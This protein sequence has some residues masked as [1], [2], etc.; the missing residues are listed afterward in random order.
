MPEPSPLLSVIMP[1]F[2]E[3]EYLAFALE[4]VLV[5]EVDFPYEIIVVDDYSTDGTAA[6]VERYRQAFPDIVR[7]AIN[8][9]N[10]GNAYSFWHGLTLSRGEFFHVLDGDDFF[11]RRDKLQRQVDFLQANPDFA[12][13]ATNSL[14]MLPDTRFYSEVP[15]D[16]GDKDYTYK[17]VLGFGF[18]FHTS[19]Y[20]YRNIYRDAVPD[21]LK[22]EW[23]RGDGVRTVLHAK[24][25]KVKYLDFIGS[26]YR[27]YAKGIWSA[28][29]QQQ[30]QERVIWALEQF[31]EKLATT[32]EERRILTNVIQYR[33]TTKGR[34]RIWRIVALL[35]RS[36]WETLCKICRKETRQKAIA[37]AVLQLSRQVEETSILKR[38]KK[39]AE[40]LLQ[41]Q[42]K[43]QAISYSQATKTK[44]FAECYMTQTTD[45]LCE[46]IGKMRLDAKSHHWLGTA[47]DDDLVVVFISGMQL[48]SGGVLREIIDLIDIHREHGQRIAVLSDELVVTPQ[49][50]IEGVPALN[51]PEVTF[52]RCPEEHTSPL[53]KAEWLMDRLCAL[54]PGRLYPFGTHHDVSI[55][56]AVQAGLAR[57]VVLDFCFDHG[58]STGTTHSAIDS[59]FVKLPYHYHMLAK[60]ILPRKLEYIPFFMEDAPEGKYR[61]YVPLASGMLT[62]MTACARSYKVGEYKYGYPHVIARILAKTGGRHIHL[63]PLEKSQMEAIQQCLAQQNMPR[64]RFVHIAWTD[65]LTQT[66]R[67]EQVDMYLQSFPVGS[68]RTSVEMMRAGIPVINHLHHSSLMFNAGDYCAPECPI[69]ETPEE[70]ENILAN[71]DEARLA[72]L[73]AHVRAFYESHND[74]RKTRKMVLARKGLH[75]PYHPR[76]DGIVSHSM[77]RE[78]V[79]KGPGMRM[80]VRQLVKRLL[81]KLRL[82][83]LVK[84]VM[85]R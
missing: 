58:L 15:P 26:V 4:S 61:S 66:A 76:Y 27:F 73:S 77:A 38:D 46:A 75:A 5:Q 28:M 9:E 10:K 20:M 2:N 12:A 84:R 42:R 71:M 36:P 47:Y 81:I 60:A 68:G 82:F 7:Y 67:E 19:S 62:T 70:L 45:Q 34:S 11:I 3:E 18:Y 31:R 85:T 57:E 52:E 25:G 40:S 63:G 35:R 74:F 55:P 64:E 80:L 43:L 69:W 13:V 17:D 32:D 1:V 79:E 56:T 23:A 22:E 14:R 54:R 83:G 21:F 33:K 29:S 53:A 30:Q 78:F 37:F 6:V 24:H 39:P 72:D 41:M 16:S 65:D 8:P 59:I 49:D 50:V 48:K 51:L 44:A